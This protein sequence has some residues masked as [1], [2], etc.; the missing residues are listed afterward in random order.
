MKTVTK[1]ITDP[2]AGT[3]SAITINGTTEVTFEFNITSNST[4]YKKVT[5]TFFDNTVESIT[6][7]LNSSTDTLNNYTFKKV[8]LS[9]DPSLCHKKIV[10]EFFKDNGGKE[11]LTIPVSL[12]NATTTQYDDINLVKV[13]Y[14]D[15][16]QSENLL[17]LTFNAGDT[18]IAGVNV[19]DFDDLT[20][21][22]EQLT[23]YKG[24]DVN[25]KYE[26]KVSLE[27]TKILI[28]GVQSYMKANVIRE[29]SVRE[30]VIVHFRT[31]T[32]ETTAA[33]S[34]GDEEVVYAP[35]RPNTN[36]YHTSGS[37][38]FYCNDLQRVQTINVPIIDSLGS[39]LS[40]FDA[41]KIKDW[42]ESTST[43][44]MRNS[45][46]ISTLATSLST[47]SSCYFFVDIISA[48]KLDNNAACFTTVCST[49]ST[50]TAYI[51]Y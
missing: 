6:T 30:D 37:L 25:H 5:V 44:V 23:Y 12:Q 51:N 24:V 36:F 9:E 20:F 14:V 18:D 48:N 34:A 11:T 8:I 26:A 39:Y 43:T 19:I 47:L 10:L 22:K 17:A 16:K 45:T 46:D 33:L 32:P 13:D 50:L 31:R 41:V 49:C 4:D 42:L 3:D 27:A 2:T 21:Q 29:G 35:A 1:E 15:N 28:N 38:M 7:D 40:S